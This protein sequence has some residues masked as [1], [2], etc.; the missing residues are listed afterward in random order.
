MTPGLQTR[1]HRPFDWSGY[2]EGFS[3]PRSPAVA[4]AQVMTLLKAVGFQQYV[5]MFARERIAGE[6]LASLSNAELRDDLG[7]KNLRHRREILSAIARAQTDVDDDG[8]SNLPEFGRIL[9]HLSNVRNFHSW[10]RLGGQH[11]IFSLA[12]TRLAPQLRPSSVVLVCALYVAA[13]GVAAQ[14]YGFVTYRLVSSVIDEDAARKRHKFRAD[15]AGMYVAT[16]GVLTTAAFVLYII[17]TGEGFS[18][19][20]V[21]VLD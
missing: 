7:I 11:L 19:S 13:A 8:G 10:M 15:V 3:N 14:V 21:P 20:D 16:G 9:V 2:A 5:E 12:L 17:L 4:D 1:A 18:N 6:M